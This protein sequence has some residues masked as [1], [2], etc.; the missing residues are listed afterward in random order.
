MPFPERKLQIALFCD[1]KRRIQR[2]AVIV[3]RLFHLVC[4]FKIKLVGGHA[5]AVFIIN[6]LPGLDA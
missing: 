3:Q 2:F 1:L 5:H 4:V 6:K